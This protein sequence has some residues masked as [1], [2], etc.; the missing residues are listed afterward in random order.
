MKKLLFLSALVVSAGNVHAF[1]QET[2]KRIVIDAVNYM[3]QNPNTTEFNKLQ[4]F[5]QSKGMTVSQLGELMGQAAYDVDDFED[6]FFCGA[7]TGDCV[8]APVWGVAKSIVKY[9]SYW[10]FQN[11]TQGAD[12]HGNDFGGYNY[13]KLT[14]WGTVD[15]MAATWLKGDYL[16]DGPGGETGWFS[17][18]DSEYNTYGITEKNYRIDS[19][20]NY[21]MYDDFEEMPFQ[22]IDNLGQ[23]WYQSYLQTGNPQ[24]LG[25]VFHTTDLLQPHHTWTTS[26][27]NHADWESWVKDYYDRENLNDMSLVSQAMQNFSPVQPNETDIRPL[28]TQGGAFSYSQGGIVLNSKDHHDRLNTAKQVIPNAIAMVVHLLNHAMVAR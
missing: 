4:N 1:S 26:D 22:P 10:H 12:Q 23:Y 19:H 21:R 15:S 24:V 11:H 17:A 7:I 9:T 20:S 8:Q 2:H 16:D 25:F 3:A 28:L 27:L 5:A 14:V 6:T 13:D 18:D